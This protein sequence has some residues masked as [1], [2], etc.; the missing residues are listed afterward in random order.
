MKSDVPR[1]LTIRDPVHGFIRLYDR[2]CDLLDT[3]PLQRL[4]GIRQLAMAYLV[5]P[6]ALH[7]RFDHTLGVIHVA[8]RFAGVLGVDPA[9]TRLVRLAALLHDVGHGPFSHVSEFVFACVTPISQS[10]RYEHGLERKPHEAITERIVLQ[11]RSL[12][13][14]LCG[15]DRPDIVDL[16]R[17]HGNRLSHEILSGALDADKQDYLLRDSY[18]CGVRYG[19]Y[20]IDQL[21]NTL[22]L[23]TDPLKNPYPLVEANGI[24]TL[25]QFVLAKHY[26]TTQVY[27]HKVRLITDAML[28]RAISLGVRMDQIQCLTKLYQYEK[29]DDEFLENYL[30]WDDNRLILEMLKPEYEQTFAGRLFR[31][32]VTRQLF[33]RVFRRR[34]N[35]FSDNVKLSLPQKLAEPVPD[36]EAEI[37]EVLRNSFNHAHLDSRDV[38]LNLIN[39]GSVRAQSRGSEGSIMVFDG[40]RAVPFEDEST[41]FRSIDE[42]LNEQWVECYAPIPP[43]GESQRKEAFQRVSSGITELL[44]KVL[45]SDG[46]A[47]SSAP[48]G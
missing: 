19:I 11:H 24:H 20:D 44:E 18:F 39:I 10:G 37:A 25:E 9:N 30:A 38:I 26:L 42:S 34:L 4:R 22:R 8:A 23:G 36:L 47:N 5:Y 3:P 46:P 1:E 15:N 16:F 28:V 12:A 35:D 7:T 2:E 32:L 33:K 21:H 13:G 31:R 14:P 41:L 45:G 17:G 40:F 43:L 27:R 48:G 29:L 6:G